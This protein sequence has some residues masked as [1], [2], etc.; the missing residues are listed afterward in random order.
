MIRH[1]F[2]IQIKKFL[3]RIGLFVFFTGIFF[4]LNSE[5][6]STASGKYLRISSLKQT[7]IDENRIIFEGAVDAIIDQKLHLSADRVEIDRGKQTL[8]AKMSD[9][10]PVKIENNDFVIL[11]DY[12]FLNLENKTGY[13]E[14]IKIHMDEGYISAKKAQKLND[15]NW[16][17]E[18][19]LFSACDQDDLHWYF[20][21]TKAVVHGSYFIDASNIIF[22]TGGIPVFYLPRMALP[23]QG[24]SKSGFLIPKFSFDYEF[25][26]G[27]K[28]EYYKYINRHCDTT[29]GL[30]F[31]TQRGAVISD[32]FRWARSPDSFTNACGQYAIVNDSY[33][34]QN[35]NIVQKTEHRYW[36]QGKDYTYLTHF[37]S[38]DFRSLIRADFG[39]DKQIGYYFSNNI[40]SVDDTFFN[41]II[42][43]G[44]SDKHL[45]ECKGDKDRT[46][47]KQFISLTYEEIGFAEKFANDNKDKVIEFND[48]LVTKKEIEDRFKTL[49]LPHFEWNPSYWSLNNLI[50]YRQDLFF[51]QIFYRQVEIERLFVNS[52]MIKESSLIPLEKHDV[53]RAGYKGNIHTCFNLKNSKIRLLVEP[54]AQF[55]S[56]TQSSDIHKKNVIEDHLFGNGA[57]RIYSKYGAEIALPDATIYSNDFSCTNFVQPIIKWTYLPKFYQ[58][59]WYYMDLWD[60]VY[61]I[62]EVAGSIS[63]NLNWK[64]WNIDLDIEQGYDFYNQSDIFYLRRG[65]R[66]RHIL[67]LK[68][69]FSI[70]YNILKF[71]VDQEFEWG[72]SRLLQSQVCAGIFKDKLNLSI[73]YFYQHPLLQQARELLS[74]VPHFV[75]VNVAIP[76]SKEVVLCYDGQFYDEKG[77]HFADLRGLKPLLHRVKMEISGHCWGFY[78]GF[79]AK[80]YRDCGNSKAEHTVVF[81]LRLDSL[82]S[83]AK[84][85]RR[86]PIIHRIEEE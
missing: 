37:G 17:M 54:E 33:A 19:I 43:R 84:K 29:F 27:M 56:N 20:S 69:D 5:I 41:S 75:F 22:K 53:F 16:R 78:L 71:S 49:K 52:R 68:Y 3:I 38:F 82:G 21:A 32:E 31:K 83:F 23:I 6:K 40:E 70:G 86:Q 13:A 18:D 4:D 44:H 9:C 25:G 61:P 66:Q 42:F 51:D 1:N 47:R 12:I 60:R 57:Y 73:G 45:F 64:N 55:R 48:N 30:D 74:N 79:E 63:N 50:F 46:V 58:D 36:I 77:Y 35:K 11:T 34:L 85:F 76:I 80:K 8:I 2:L 81:S 62:N 15:F 14:N 39:T 65:V 26:F 24:H 72:R 10:G 7:V 28:V 59:N 67:P